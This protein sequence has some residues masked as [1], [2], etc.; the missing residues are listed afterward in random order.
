MIDYINVNVREN[1]NAPEVFNTVGSPLHL[2][3]LSA[4]SHSA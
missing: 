2:V 1:C 3:E 4:L